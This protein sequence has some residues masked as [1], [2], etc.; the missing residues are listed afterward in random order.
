VSG[1]DAGYTGVRVAVLGA[2]G[3]IGR[4]VARKLCAAGACTYLIV[5][6]RERAATTFAKYGVSGEV[7]E[8]GLSV[9]GVLGEIYSRIRPAITFNLVGYGI[10]VTERDEAISYRI[11]AGL[12]E[13]ICSA[14]AAW[15]DPNWSGQQI[16]HTGS[17]LEYGEIG[18]DLREDGG[19]CPT[20]IYGKSKL[21]GTHSIAKGCATIGLRGVTARLFTVYGPGEHPGRLLPSLIET[22]RTGEPLKLTAGTQRRDF[23]YIED[24]A[25]GLLRLGLAAGI[26]AGDVINLAT[27][28]LTSV[29]KFIE[30]A[31]TILKIPAA[32]LQFG[33]LATRIEEMEHCDTSIDK[34]RTV[35]SWVP[36][37]SM[38][39]GLRASILNYQ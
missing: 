11:N 30:T 37:T 31:A 34:L 21:K 28:R 25:D 1:F 2:S 35:L 7:L 20:T 29:R 17:A 13:D 4:W 24:V 6:D 26:E 3:F 18:G 9:T 19:A 23:T 14:V 10:D 33:R 22:S 16:V 38:E 15:R 12:P 39:A 5:R 32:N 8:A 36:P 27:G